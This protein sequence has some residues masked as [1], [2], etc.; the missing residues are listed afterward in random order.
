MKGFLNK[1]KDPKYKLV[2]Y[3]LGIFVIFIFALMLPKNSN[4]TINNPDN[5]DIN[6]NGDKVTNFLA[7]QEDY[8]YEFKYTLKTNN[9]IIIY[10]GNKT[11]EEENITLIE[12]DITKKFLIKDG[13]TY[14]EKDDTYELYDDDIYT[15]KVDIFTNGRLLSS[16]INKGYLKDNT[17]LINLKDIIYNYEGDEYI[18]VDSSS[19]NNTYIIN[20]EYKSLLNY[21]YEDIDSANLELLYSNITKK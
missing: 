1:M 11:K 17:Y 16:Y 3:L 15:N 9:K 20:I 18:K 4:N 21:I 2:G 6:N 8:T 10:E 7:N 13:F 5:N 19:N 12:D 14:I